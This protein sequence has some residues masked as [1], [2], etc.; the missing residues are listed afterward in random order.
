MNRAEF[1]ARVS[2]RPTV[3]SGRIQLAYWLAKNAHRPF[4]RDS[5]ER[6]F[7][8][9]RAVALSLVAHGYRGTDYI[10][11]GLLHDVIEDTN[12]PAT[13]IVDL[14]GPEMWR[15]LEALSR[16]LPLLDP[17]TGQLLWRYKKSLDEY[18]QG[19]NAAP[20]DVKVTKCA[21]RLNNLETCGV[22]EQA[23]RDRY[24]SETEQYVLPIAHELPCSY[25]SEIEAV[26][27][28]LKKAV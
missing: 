24:V 19:I 22:W 12:T 15:S 21:D 9:P 26:I 4:Y 18:Y 10:V 5:G 23:R 28:T 17:V 20:I 25:A 3:E 13:V 2:D 8:H 14:F 7:E 1:F 16:Y 11:R 6:F 27:A